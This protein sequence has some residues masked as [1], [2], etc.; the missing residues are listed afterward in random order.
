MTGRYSGLWKDSALKRGRR[1]VRSGMAGLDGSENLQVGDVGQ[2]RRGMGAAL[3]HA[4]K[5]DGPRRHSPRQCFTTSVSMGAGAPPTS[6]PRHPPSHHPRR[7]R[8][9]GLP[10]PCLRDPCF[11]RHTHASVT[12]LCLLTHVCLLLAAHTHT[13]AH[14]HT[15]AHLRICAGTHAGTHLEDGPVYPSSFPLSSSL[16]PEDWDGPVYPGYRDARHQVEPVHARVRVRVHACARVW[17]GG[18]VGGWAG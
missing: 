14:I 13:H 10:G 3:R 17:V 7:R 5:P 16:G 6:P 1:G 15:R 4:S 18:W 11:W 2:V 9:P 8:H 12:L